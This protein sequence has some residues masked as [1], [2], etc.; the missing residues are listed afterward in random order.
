[1]GLSRDLMTLVTRLTGDNG[2]VVDETIERGT[3][4]S[5]FRRYTWWTLTAAVVSVLVIITGSWLLDTGVPTWARG[6]GGAALAI[7]VVAS[8]VLFNR[9]LGS[10][11]GLAVASRPAGWLVVGGAGAAALGTVQLTLKEYGLWA[12]A[13]AMMV[14]IGA[15]FMSA[16]GQRILVGAALAIAPLPGALVCL[17]SG[18]DDLLYAAAFPLGLMLFTAWT[19]LGPL[20]AWDVAGRLHQARRL[21]A[22]LAVKD[23]RLRFAADL[24]DIQGHQLQVIAFK[25]E[26]AARLVEVDPAR[27]AAEMREVRRLSTDTIQETRAL[28]QGYRRT[29][30]E[31]EISNA[32]RVLAAADIDARMDLQPVAE[33]VCAPSR[34]LLGLVMREATT[35]VLRHSRAARADV[36]Y[37]VDGGQ[38]HLRV[39]ND[40]A[41]DVPGAAP[42][43]G[44]TTLAE[45]LTAAGGD[46]TWHHDKDRFVVA[47]SLPV[48]TP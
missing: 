9:R 25:S 33:N 37:R 17:L 2:H 16:R 19:T 43:T 13:P 20:W 7:T 47:A 26:L 30:L 15:A 14:A 11:P 31:E 4:L 8:V 36:E 10:E 27:A 5:G 48:T 46:L 44:L 32:T 3:G 35:N 24:H 1:M 28:V 40:G 45:R 6:V 12:V 23:E 34:H 22:E 41:V 21:S 42:G 38:A 29:T 39:S 18:Q